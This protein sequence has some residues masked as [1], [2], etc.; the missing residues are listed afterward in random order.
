MKPRPQTKSDSKFD[1]QIE[2]PVH[3]ISEETLATETMA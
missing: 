3:L 1:N 2:K